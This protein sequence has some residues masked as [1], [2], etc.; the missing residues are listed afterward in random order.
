MSPVPIALTPS[1]PVGKFLRSLNL[2][3]KAAQMYG[4]E[5]GQTSAKSQDAWNSLES[6]LEERNGQSLQL[7]VTEKRLL[8]DGEAVKVG[9]AEQSFT[10][11]LAAA[12]LASAASAHW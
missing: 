1:S 7:A 9:P 5:H 3:L 8:I 11:L 6:A 12:D 2:L 10:T 4:M